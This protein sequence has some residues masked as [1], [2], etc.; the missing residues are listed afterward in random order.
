MRIVAH[1]LGIVVFVSL[2]FSCTEE[3][4]LDVA[5]NINP[6]K[7]PTMLTT[8][9]NMVVSDSGVPQ[10]KIVTPIWYVYDEVDTPLYLLPE[11]LYLE[12]FDKNLKV[13]AS[14]A[15]DSA[16]NYQNDQLW[17]L[18]GNVELRNGDEE[19]IRTHE[20]FWNQRTQK[21]YNDTSFIQIEQPDRV[22]E[23][24]GF[25]GV[26]SERSLSSYRIKKPTGIFPIDKEKLGS[27]ENPDVTNT[28]GF[29]NP[30]QASPSVA[31][32]TEIDVK[33]N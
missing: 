17:Q 6:E 27:G 21:I 11:G 18:I 15:C 2:M 31:R 9:V 16:I 32:P 22:I 12:K 13:I 19:V 5:A 14:V 30:S 25:D 3:K 1:I 4:K 33:N 8:N 29:S 10:F 26:M 24:Y 7:M 28:P 20:L 23:G